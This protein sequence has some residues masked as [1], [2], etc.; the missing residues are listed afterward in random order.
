[1]GEKPGT[2][3]KAGLWVVSVITALML[4]F[5]SIGPYAYFVEKGMLPRKALVWFE[6]IYAPIDWL[7]YHTPLDRTISAYAT[8]W[9]GLAHAP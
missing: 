9:T 8:W 5:L 7:Y 6:Y 3:S 1:M 2:K 4:Y